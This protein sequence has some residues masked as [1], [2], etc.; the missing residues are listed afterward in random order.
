MRFEKRFEKSKAIL[1]ITS[2]LCILSL[3]GCI[4]SLYKAHIEMKNREISYNEKIKQLTLS[5]DALI[6]EAES[7]EKTRQSLK[8]QLEDTQ[9][10]MER[11]TMQLKEEKE[12]MPEVLPEVRVDSAKVERLK[13]TLAA[14][15][16]ENIGLKKR[17]ELLKEDLEKQLDEIISLRRTAKKEMK[18]QRKKTE[19]M[20]NQE[21]ATSL[22]TI[23]VTE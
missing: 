22:G 10:I 12:K 14:Y 23:V 17:V 8:S 3:T 19:K 13:N 2:I 7:F 21:E 18:E 20:A 11:L 6:I 16:R 5:R 9:K 1:Y 15:R 4:Y